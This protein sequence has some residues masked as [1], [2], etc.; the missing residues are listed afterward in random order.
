MRVNATTAVLGF[1]IVTSLKQF[2]SFLSGSAEIGLTN[3]MKGMFTYLTNP[4][5]TTALI[6]KYSPE[7]AARVLEREIA[8][9]RLARGSGQRLIS[10]KLT[11]RETF[12]FL[13]LGMDKIAVNSLWR[14]AFDSGLKNGMEAE[15]AA[16][17]ATRTIR[18]TQ[19]YF[20]VKDLAEF[21]RSKD[22]LVRADC[23]H[24]TSL[25]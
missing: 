4:K 8:E 22:E 10:G 16:R 9:A 24:M 2:P 7:L 21:W 6:K 3:A 11:R 19:P 25:L 13:T 17:F 5:E 1:N 20:D 12:M 14:G 23:F 18:R 15:E